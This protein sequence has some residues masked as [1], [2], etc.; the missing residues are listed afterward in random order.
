[1]TD[2]SFFQT[3]YDRAAC[4]IGMVHI[5]YGAFHRAHQ[6]VYLDDYMQATGDL[7]WGIAAVNLRASESE[8]FA[9]AAAT[10]SGYLLKS[11][12]PDGTIEFRT[13][14]S[15]RAFV[16]AATDMAAALDLFARPGVHAVSMT[17]TESGYSF[18]EDWSLDLKASAI[19]DELS[20]GAIQTIY[21]FLTAALE[22]RM[23]TSN[24]PLTVLCCDNIRNN[25]KVLRAALLSYLNAAG[26]GALAR[27][28]EANTTFPC[29]MVD[30][31]TPRAT[32]ELESEAKRLFPKI[33]A[34]PVHAE[35]FL[36]WVLQDNFAADMPDLTQAGVQVVEDVEPFEE[37]KIRI[38]NGGHTG[39][40]YLGALGGHATFDQAML[41]PDL[42]AYFDR[43]ERDNV[44]PG[45]EGIVPFDTTAYLGQ[46]AQRFENPGIAD[47]LERICMD[48]WGKMGIFIR[49]T[50]KA[51]LNKGI[52]PTASYDCVASWVVYARKHHAGTMPIPYVEP[53]WDR[54][55]PL[56]APGNETALAT[57]PQLWG[58]LPTRFDSFVPNLISAIQRM[59][60]KWQD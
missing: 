19:A 39:L 4:E 12:A 35:D 21:G 6:A 9:E 32:P 40:A 16:D 60:E 43:F 7:R 42:R 23:K 3:G 37:A 14:R 26:N 2:T 13:V 1:M 28:V 24:A 49:P 50:I 22:H 17:V 46:I 27:W 58:D 15:H 56:L 52:E 59:E 30:R 57:E 47:Q 48:G 25:G 29:S 38:L 51:C 55:E 18:R 20:G 41:D 11:I 36:Q 54:L 8:S 31:I 53:A 5:G 44:L 10:D 33:A 34:T 45:L